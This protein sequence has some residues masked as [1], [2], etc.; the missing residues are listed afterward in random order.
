MLARRTLIG[1]LAITATPLAR[2]LAA[3]APPAAAKLTT[4][5]QAEVSQVETYLNGIKTLTSNFEQVSGAGNVATGKLYLSRPGRM[6]FEYDAPVPILLVA[7]GLDIHYYD[8]ELKQVT[9]LRIEGTPAAFLLRERIALSGGVTLTRFDH[10][11]GVIRLTFVETSE[12]G[13]GSVTLALT[14]RPLEL[15]QW[16][17]VDAQQKRVT[18]TLTD[19][20]Y[21]AAVDAKLF[22]WTDPR[23]TDTGH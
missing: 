16:T 15:R 1:A 4:A 3:Q 14:D 9:D 19:P 23:P 8:R 5:Q 18:V 12:P 17:V 10:Q 13:Q 6:R 2:V 7:D 22:Q 20:H 11:P 21:G